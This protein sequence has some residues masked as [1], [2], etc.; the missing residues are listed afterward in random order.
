MLTMGGGTLGA[1]GSHAVDSFRWMLGAE[2]SEVCC[3]L[4]T[5]V[6]ERPDKA[7]GTMRRGNLGRRRS[8]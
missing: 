8:S 4:S 1:I 5:H 2:V 6:A 3:M 7:S